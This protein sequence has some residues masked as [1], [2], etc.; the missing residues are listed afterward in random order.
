MEMPKIIILSAFILVNLALIKPLWAYSNV[1]VSI[2]P[3]HSLVLNI[4]GNSEKTTLLLKGNENPH[5]FSIK[6]SQ[7]EALQNSDLV[8][9]IGRELEHSLLKPISSLATKAKSLS[10]LESETIVKIKSRDHSNFPLKDEHHDGHHDEHTDQHH[11]GHHDEHTDEHHDEHADEHGH[12][13]ES[14]YDPHLWL[15]PIIAKK[16]VKLVTRHLVKIDPEN[17]DIYMNNKKNT[18]TNLDQLHTDIEKILL[19]VK[20]KK[21]IASHDAYYYFEKRYGLSTQGSVSPAHHTDISAS[22]LAK[23]VEYTRNNSN[24]CIF[25]LPEDKPKVLKLNILP[26]DQVYVVDPIG[27]DIT[28]GPQLYFTLI[29]N[30][31]NNFQECLN[32][33][34]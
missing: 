12:H 34:Q 6:P 33:Q 17:A 22:R 15:D 14:I 3:L 25:T 30:M 21:F 26:D 10:M 27:R 29:R 7:A 18:L 1:V 2:A 4:T 28:P 24:V 9:W 31:A 16:A 23:V 19:S 5:S 32:K 13:F 20:D 8:V 11:D